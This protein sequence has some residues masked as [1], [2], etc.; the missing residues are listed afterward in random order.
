VT[1]SEPGGRLHSIGDPAE[2]V[3]ATAV[4]VMG[5]ATRWPG[6]SGGAGAPPS[7]VLRHRSLSGPGPVW[8]QTND[9]RS[10]PEAE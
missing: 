1:P 7:V 8:R 6:L 2:E 3:C 9:R 4:H 10:W 5:A